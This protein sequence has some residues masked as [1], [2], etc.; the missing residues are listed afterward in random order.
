MDLTQYDIA[1]SAGMDRG[2]L[3]DIENGKKD[4]RLST[5]VRLCEALELE[6]WRVIKDAF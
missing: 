5:L 6:P 1:A 3:S 4:I 2:Y